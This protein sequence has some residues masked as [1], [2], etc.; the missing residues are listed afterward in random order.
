MNKFSMIPIAL[1]LSSVLNG[2]TSFAQPIAPAADGTN[3]TVNPEG[4]QFN[5]TGGTLSG[6][7]TNL[8]HSFEQFGLDSG[9]VA[10]FLSSPEIQNILGRV[11]GGDASIINGLIQITGGNSNLFLMNPAGI[12]FGPNASLNVPAS[13]TATTATGIGFGNDWFQAVG[14]NNWGNLIGTPSQ[15]AFEISQPGVIAN[16]GNLTLNPGQNLTLLG[17][18][19]LNAGTL[20][21]PGGNITVA[22]VPG[23]SR[24][25]IFQANHV[26]SLEVTPSDET[27]LT[28]QLTPMSLPE[29]L[30]GSGVSHAN[31]VQVNP[32]GTIALTGSHSQV[33]V[34][35]G[36]AVAS[37][38][39]N[40]TGEAGGTV[41]VLGER[42]AVVGAH[43]DA[44]GI[45]GGGT[46][47]VG[48]EYQ[49]QGPIPNASDTLVSRDSII[50]ADALSQGDG[51]R[52]II[53]ADDTTTF[54]GTINARG[55]VEATDEPQNG[56]F[57]EVS[58]KKNL[59][60]RGSVDL[61]APNGSLG[62]L[63]LDPENIIIVSA[64]G[65]ADDPQLSEGVP[66]PGDPEGAIFAEDGGT[67]SYTISK[68]VLETL[69]GNGDII[70]E[71]TN[72]III[73]DLAYNGELR[74][75]AG[76]GEISFV[77]DA[78]G[79]GTGSFLM[80]NTQNTI[81]APGRSVSISGASIVVGNINT[82]I[83]FAPTDG[84]AITLNATNGSITGGEL[85]AGTNPLQ[86]EGMAGNGG[87]VT[88]SALTDI[89]LTNIA[90]SSYS[91]D[92]G[93][94]NGGR[95]EVRSTTGNITVQTL[96]SSTI[97]DLGIVGNG[98]EILV[99]ALNGFVNTS[100]IRSNA[101]SFDGTAG[102]GG[103]IVVNAG[104][105]VTVSN[106]LDSSS[107][108]LNSGGNVELTGNQIELPIEGSGVSNN[109]G[110][111]LLQP[112]T[113]DTN[114]AI[115]ALTIIP[116]SLTL[117]QFQ[118]GQLNS[119]FESV[120]IGRENGTGTVTLDS[121]E[122]PIDAPL[123]VRS[124]NG[125]INVNSPIE[126]VDIG[127]ITLQ[128]AT[129]L[130]S[131]LTTVNQ[132][133]A[134]QGDVTLGLNPV[135]LTSGDGEITLTGQVNGNQSLTLDAGIGEISIT[136]EIGGVTPIG[137]LTANSTGIT[138]FGGP[139]NATSLTT[140]AGGTTQL[141]G[142]VTTTGA[143]GQVYGNN[144]TT[145]GNLTLTGDELS[146][147]GTVTGTG[148]LTLQPANVNTPVA[149]GDATEIGVGTLDITAA[150][151]A[152]FQGFTS[153]TIGRIDG[154][155]AISSANLSLTVPTTIQSGNGG[156]TLAGANGAQPLT[157][158]STNGTVALSGAVGD[159][160][161]LSS[162]TVTTGG[163]ATLGN[164]I[165]TNGPD[166]VTIAGTGGIN[167]TGPV[168]LN[169][170][171]GNGTVALTGA[172]NGNFPLTV[173][174]GNGTVTL[175]AI[176]NITPISSLTLNS[177]NTAQ[178]TGNITTQGINGV[179][180]NA[181]TTLASPVT[182]NTQ[183]GN[184]PINFAG[185]VDGTFPLTLTAGTGNVRF[186]QTLGGIFPLTQLTIAGG[187]LETAN[188]N[189]GSGGINLTGSNITLNTVN[190]TAGGTLAINNSGTLN[191]AG[192]VN[193]AGLFS[194]T[195]TGSVILGNNLT[196]TNQNISFNSPITLTGNPE[197]SAGTGSLSFNNTL[198][199][200]TG[201]LSLTANEMQFGGVISGTGLAFLSP[202]SSDRTIQIGGT[203]SNN[204]LNLSLAELNLF[205]PGFTQITIGRVDSTGL[206]SIAPLTLSNQ[207]F[208]FQSGNGIIS[209]L[210]L[211]RGNLG[212]DFTFFAN[213][214]ELAAGIETDGTDIVLD[215]NVKLAAD[216]TLNTGPGEG[217]ITFQRTVNGT[218]QLT[219]QAGTGN[220]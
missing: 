210:G 151:L 199:A 86:G 105:I 78:D 74:F 1:V 169:S 22:A 116:N 167:L 14:E 207:S 218:H 87:A 212:A 53:W 49:G 6:D 127:S 18:T 145:P 119:G 211:L 208:F 100:T 96:N 29:L 217:N 103:N 198:N 65:A 140:N 177:T 185:A 61:S 44:S 38:E 56:G 47:L 182:I 124:P 175:P 23:E 200:G 180:V 206:I 92:M 176:G 112:S 17:G 184:G 30:T 72:D 114:I 32:D 77:A 160:T 186:T 55:G 8:F 39:L 137:D 162:L 40:V 144:V 111:L 163:I 66:N 68:F 7:R 132:P 3:T 126:A 172:V 196:T 183:I 73:E 146:F 36:D 131:N 54:R 156:I 43:I 108:E 134:I 25:R 71:A 75:E 2:T 161:P 147:G 179:T 16:L 58:G 31:Q 21:S 133:I 214:I 122:N 152:A 201:N 150:D 188:L 115:N 123:T 165:T 154:N 113:P 215:G 83:D 191:L 41:Q 143:V 81:S 106:I 157:V 101:D 197:I 193:L 178:L 213:D 59:I 171:T 12:L 57:V 9:Q 220:V 26:L 50:S 187:I 19:V 45:D 109:G 142:N 189:V 88:I 5:I 155:G 94:S 67:A 28:S 181:P 174:S 62:T 93:A 27:P 168:T 125:A 80:Q 110:M 205:Q 70:L 219:L 104:T 204:A 136:G 15:F 51:G 148:L 79:S 139:I 130:N 216:V 190:T 98:G 120:T 153:L 135:I 90:T 85:L 192:L 138:Q 48:G 166:G 89:N 173:T 52:V 203:S 35:F 20:A 10:N 11:T 102:T 209:L 118:I 33:P 4:N 76:T 95:I 82:G 97:T 202:G 46:V 37:G 158:T 149:L 91:F 164:A 117:T 195:G 121:F 129:T 128:G 64:T 159:I 34:E 170:S 107:S 99:E 63:L 194:Q 69:P 141:N 24:V 60:F 84:G 42:V 13:F